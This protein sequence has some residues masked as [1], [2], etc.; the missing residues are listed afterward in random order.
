MAGL[1]VNPK[2][3]DNL[4]SQK[5]SD[6]RYWIFGLR[7]VGEFGGLIAIPVVLFVL[8]GRWL[9]G[10]WGTKPL[11]IIVG[12]VVAA[13]VSGMMV[14]RRSKEVAEEY[15]KL[16]NGENSPNSPKV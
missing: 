13:V 15:Q 1:L 4:Q 12:F 6:S 11:F 8:A 5:Q 9:D 14:W 16:V 3:V 7:I 2:C 10:R